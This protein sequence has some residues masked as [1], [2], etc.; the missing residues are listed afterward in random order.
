[1]IKRS[2]VL[3]GMVVMGLV[4]LGCAGS[5]PFEKDLFARPNRLEKDFGTS[6]RAQIVNQTLNPEAGKD[7]DP[8]TGFDGKAAQA[9]TEKYRKE[10]EKPAPPA[11]YVLGIGSM[12][13]KE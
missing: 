3:I 9:T 12:S 6:F 10:F 4:V 13:T 5:C 11:P 2:L 8:V 7:L 1:M